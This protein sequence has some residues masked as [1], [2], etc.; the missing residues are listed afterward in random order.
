MSFPS[1]PSLSK[2]SINKAGKDIARNLLQGDERRVAL[3]KINAWRVAH[4]YPINT[5]VA[6][7][8][9]KTRKY[10]DPVVAQR[11]KRLPT[12]LDKLKRQPHMDLTRMQDIGG[13]RAILSSIDD[14]KSLRNDYVEKGRFSHALID[15]DDYV[16]V[17]KSDGYR[18]IHLIYS[19]NNTLSRTSDPSQYKGLL[20]E[21]QMRTQLQHSWATAVETVGVMRSEALKS[22][23][24][25]RDWLDFFEY[26]SSVFAI[27]EDSP[28]LPQHEN[29]ST[30]EIFEHAYRLIKDLNVLEV[31]K[32]WS[33]ATGAIH[34]EG[35]GGYYNIILLNKTTKMV[36]IIGYAKDFVKE[37]SAKYAELE[38]EASSNGTP[39][40]VLVS[41]G[42]LENLKKAYPN[43]F[44]D[45]K[46]FASHIEEI[47]ETVKKD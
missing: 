19:Y 4:A 27:A 9:K 29:M 33:V 16:A 2:S 20:V 13:V 47:V 1:V 38:I 31:L 17:P 23:K 40:P 32:G 25:N 28:I 26:V 14:L 30:I 35:A 12:I 18:G 11:L 43:Y 36:R 6:T 24:G 22:Q 34:K 45:I 39:E 21:L 41:A 10:P 7:L 46:K 8:R 37:A 15:E 3:S 42:D 44:L 5:F